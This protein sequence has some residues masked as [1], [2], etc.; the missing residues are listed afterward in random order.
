MTLRYMC[1]QIPQHCGL[2]V[3]TTYAR[4]DT[5]H[6]KFEQPS[7]HCLPS[8]D[9]DTDFSSLSDYKDHPACP[10]SALCFTASLLCTTTHLQHFQLQRPWLSRS[11]MLAAPPSLSVTFVG[12]F[13][14]GK[15]LVRLEK[16]SDQ[17]PIRTVVVSPFLLCAQ[18]PV[19]LSCD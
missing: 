10:P 18:Q 15:A 8:F 7:L 6:Y 9:A 12:A 4:D 16:P 17:L 13:V 19:W 1:D 3:W 2:Q 14:T 11:I 5:C